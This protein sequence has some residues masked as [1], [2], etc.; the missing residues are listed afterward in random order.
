[1]FICGR[2]LAL[3]CW[4]KKNLHTANKVAFQQTVKERLQFLSLSV[5]CLSW[6]C[7]VKQKVRIK[8]T[9]FKK[10][11]KFKKCIKGLTFDILKLRTSLKYDGKQVRNV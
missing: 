8:G 3:I 7:S 9:W 6:R 5:F 10:K 11:Y 2:V 1:M 4:A